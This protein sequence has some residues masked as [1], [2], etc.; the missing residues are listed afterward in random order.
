MSLCN[1]AK[2]AFEKLGF[3]S[4]IARMLSQLG[5]LHEKQ[6]ELEAAEKYCQQALQILEELGIKPYV[7]LVKKDLERV[8]KLKQKP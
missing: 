6:G 3:Q 8:Q 4:E 5:R 7:E 1:E 2:V